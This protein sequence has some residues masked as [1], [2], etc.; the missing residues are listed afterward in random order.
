MKKDL[1]KKLEEPEL[2]P[3]LED[4]QYKIDYNFPISIDEFDDIISYIVLHS[5]LNR[6]QVEA[7]V[8]DFFHVVRYLLLQG[9]TIEFHLFGRFFLNTPKHGKK[10]IFVG[11]QPS[12]SLS[13]QIK[14]Q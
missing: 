9:A 8:K 7:I 13:R 2:L 5:D 6:E 4:Y 1:K 3:D 12:P 11:F 14:E 10:R